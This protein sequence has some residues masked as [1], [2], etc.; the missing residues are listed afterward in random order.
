MASATKC[1]RTNKNLFVFFWVDFKA[2][3]GLI[4]VAALVPAYASSTASRGKTRVASSIAAESTRSIEGSIAVDVKGIEDYR[5]GFLCCIVALDKRVGNRV[6]EGFLVLFI[7]EDVV[8]G[9]F[10]D[11]EERV[12]G[13]RQDI[14]EECLHGC[15]GH[16]GYSV[17][18]CYPIFKFSTFWNRM[19]LLEKVLCHPSFSLLR[20][21]V[22]ITLIQFWWIAVWGLGYIGIEYVT[23]GSKQKELFLYFGILL[24]VLLVF[25][26]EP[27]LLEKL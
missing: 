7:Y 1:S 26:F 2:R 20:F 16:L 10:E 6:E 25:Q 27:T 22:V 24:A 13:N 23:K 17:L 15:L 4:E 21:L 5:D 14:A 3:E 9:T 12:K 19:K 8:N 18:K 11:G